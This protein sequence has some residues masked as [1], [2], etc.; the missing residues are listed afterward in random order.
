MIRLV[1]KAEVLEVLPTTKG[2]F[3][4]FGLT[5]LE[6]LMRNKEKFSIGYKQSIKKL[7]KLFTRIRKEFYS[8]KTVKRFSALYQFLVLM[9]ENEFSVIVQV[10][11]EFLK[12]SLFLKAVDYFF[13]VLI[14]ALFPDDQGG[15]LGKDWNFQIRDCHL[16]ALATE[17][18]VHVSLS[19][20]NQ[21]K[22][23]YCMQRPSA[24]LVFFYFNAGIYCIAKGLEKIQLYYTNKNQMSSISFNLINTLASPSDSLHKKLVSIQKSIFNDSS[25]KTREIESFIKQYQLD[26]SPQEDWFQ[27]SLCYLYKKEVIFKICDRSHVL[28]AKCSK[29]KHC[30]ACVVL[31]QN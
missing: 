7:I 19:E 6:T 24:L 5:Y 18:R 3:V 8:K 22:A 11:T 17:L 28:C 15:L 13:R 20:C 29:R 23:F 10:W 2:F 4:A 27:C 14:C 9:N 26:W 1:E 31:S 16:Q 30:S 21:I 25:I 12:K